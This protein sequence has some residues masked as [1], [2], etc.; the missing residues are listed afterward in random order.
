[1]AEK[2][3][4]NAPASSSQTTVTRIKAADAKPAA[5]NKAPKE[6]IATKPETKTEK[7]AKI[8]KPSAKGIARPFVAIGGYFKGAG[9]ELKQVRWPNRRATWSLTATVLLYS[10]FFV[11]R[12]L[13][14]DGGFTLLIDAI[15]GK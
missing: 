7:K 6:K 10:A 11:V 5:I 12:V 4:A 3:K 9:V 14:R 8:K 1:M 2:K 13:L 15:L